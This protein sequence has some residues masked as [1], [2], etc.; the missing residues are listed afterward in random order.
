MRF[1]HLRW[2]TPQKRAPRYL[3]A[4]VIHVVLDASP[5]RPLLGRATCF[6]GHV[7]AYGFIR[8]SFV[9]FSLSCFHLNLV[10]LFFSFPLIAIATRLLALPLFST[11]RPLSRIDY[12]SFSAFN[13]DTERHSHTTPCGLS[14]AGLLLSPFP[15]SLSHI[16]LTPSA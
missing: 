5:V 6:I 1:A 13:V 3:S 16:L 10:A 7:A 9:C 8:F 11:L 2:L 15:F 14:P 12:H 4:R